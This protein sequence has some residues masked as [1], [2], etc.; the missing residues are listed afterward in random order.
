MIPTLQI[1]DYILVNK[2]TYGIRLPVLNKKVI[3]INLPQRGDVM[4]FRYPL[5][6]LH[7]ACCRRSGV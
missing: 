2:F 6:G 5:D 4:A 3:D 1:G 7:Q